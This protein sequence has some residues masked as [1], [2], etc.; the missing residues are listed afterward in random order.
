MCG[1]EFSLTSFYGNFSRL[2]A[3]SDELLG[4][5]SVEDGETLEEICPWH[6]LLI[7]LGA[8]VSLRAFA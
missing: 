3:T 1:A 6:S 4:P 5:F 8:S 7:P 2:V